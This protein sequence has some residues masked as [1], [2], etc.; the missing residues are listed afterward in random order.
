MPNQA[1][2]LRRWL[3]ADNSYEVGFGKPPKHTQF[4]KGRSGNPKGRP[5]GSK[6]IY[7][8]IQ[9]VLEE[10]VVVKG[11]RGTN[12]MSKFE[13]ALTQQVNKAAGGDAKAFREVLRLSEKVQDQEPYLNAPTFTVNWVK[14]A[15]EAGEKL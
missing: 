15:E 6:N 4:Q 8:L 13:A 12:S 7:A 10:K 2:N 5:R 3:V 1:R 9:K 14:A 11:P